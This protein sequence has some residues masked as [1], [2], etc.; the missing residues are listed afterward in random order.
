[1]TEPISTSLS[2]HTLS[3]AQGSLLADGIRRVYGDTYPMTDLY[4]MDYVRR[5]INGGLLHTVVA[6]NGDSEV[7]GQMSTVLEEVGDVTADGSALMVDSAYRGLGITQALGEAMLGVYQDCSICGLHLYALAIHQRVQKKSIGAGAAVTGILP[8]WFHAKSSIEGYRHPS[9]YRIG[10]V[11]LYMPL[12]SLP[13]RE[14]Y[15]PPVYSE[16]LTSIYESLEIERKLIPAPDRLPD[17]AQTKVTVEDKPSNGHYRLRVDRI[18]G[19]FLERLSHVSDGVSGHREVIYIDLPLADHAISYAV[20]EAR[21]RGFFF[22]SLMVDRC[23]SDR[24]RLQSY[25]K[26]CVMPDAMVIHGPQGEN[27][28]ELVLEEQ[29]ALCA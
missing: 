3:A 27:L 5:M 19:D 6:M 16:V 11:P 14:S 21:T 22:G 18:G 1:M 8:A 24:L 13:Y 17:S 20:K 15:I 28:L 29:R 10:A 26:H 9:G 23:G 12:K 25:S 2:F 7:V 4:D